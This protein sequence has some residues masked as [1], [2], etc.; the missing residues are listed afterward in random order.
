MKNLLIFVDPL[1]DFNKEHKVLVEIQLDWCLETWKP[2]DIMLVTNFPYEYRGVKATQVEDGCYYPA[3]S[4]ATKVPVINRL[5][6]EGLINDYFWFH[7]FDAFQI[8]PFPE[9]RS[10]WAI[11]QYGKNTKGSPENKWNAGSFF[12]RIQEPFRLIEKVMRDHGIDEE[13]ALTHM[14]DYGFG[15]S[16]YRPEILDIKYNTHIYSPIN[17]VMVAHFHPFKHLNIFKDI[18]PN[19]LKE[20]FKKHGIR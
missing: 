4:R 20:I 15:K 10:D 13:E 18:L 16:I 3:F 7:D 2:E 19:K 5:F 9:I 6:E 17:D 14:F 1:K 8:R 11:T 12:F